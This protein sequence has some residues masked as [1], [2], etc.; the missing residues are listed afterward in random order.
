MCHPASM[1][2]LA[3]IDVQYNTIRQTARQPQSYNASVG[4]WIVKIKRHHI[5]HPWACEDELCRNQFGNGFWEWETTLEYNVVSHWLSPY[6][7]LFLDV[8]CLNVEKRKMVV[9]YHGCSVLANKI[10]NKFVTFTSKRRFEVIITYLLRI[11]F[12]GLS[13]LG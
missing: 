5:A 11:R 8:D 2:Q 4:L 1:S 7:E 13:R 3:Y 6:S 12:V 9:R 10:R